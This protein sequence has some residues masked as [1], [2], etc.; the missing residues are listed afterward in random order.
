M[1][2]KNKKKKF[3]HHFSGRK[4]GSIKGPE[5]SVLL[6]HNLE[7]LEGWGAEA[8]MNVVLANE[9]KLASKEGRETSQNKRLKISKYNLNNQSRLY[10]LDKFL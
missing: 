3:R 8:A 10:Y 1:F 2:T 7:V 5:Y 4:E 6:R 9:E